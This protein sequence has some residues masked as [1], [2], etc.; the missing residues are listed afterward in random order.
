MTKYKKSAILQSPKTRRK[1]S[2]MEIGFFEQMKENLHFRKK[3]KI[4]ILSEGGEQALSHSYRDIRRIDF[5]L[6]RMKQGQY[7]LCTNCGCLIEK[8]RLEIIPETP[9]CSDC[10]KAIECH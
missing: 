7:G 1:E 4:K 3:S 5:A 8:D 10:A 6:L 9:F 2:G